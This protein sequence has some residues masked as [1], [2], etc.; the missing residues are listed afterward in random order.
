[1]CLISSC[2]P[3]A[4]LGVKDTSNQACC[5]MLRANPVV[6]K[7]VLVLDD[8]IA[9]VL[10]SWSNTRYAPS[11]SSRRSKLRGQVFLPLD[12]AT[13]PYHPN[14]KTATFYSASTAT[15]LKDS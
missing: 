1:M 6:A 7:S 10:S 3:L 11:S 12:D 14:P 2:A 13:H 8:S 15:E 5:A 4:L 9:D